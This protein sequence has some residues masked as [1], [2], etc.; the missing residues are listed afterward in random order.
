[1]IDCDVN[2]PIAYSRISKSFEVYWH[3]KQDHITKYIQNNIL[4][5]FFE[6]KSLASNTIFLTSMLVQFWQDIWKA[7]CS[8]AHPQSKNIYSNK[9][10][11]KKQRLSIK[12]T[13]HSTVY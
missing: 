5:R 4:Q 1:M 6:N 8:L 13:N 12:P 10:T 11:T 9:K 3:N 2:Y 7:S